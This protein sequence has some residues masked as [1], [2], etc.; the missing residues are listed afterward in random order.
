MSPE[1]AAISIF[2]NTSQTWK[3]SSRRVSK[4]GKM[5]KK[6]K[7]KKKEKRHESCLNSC[8]SGNHEGLKYTICLGLSISCVLR[9][10][11]FF[12]RKDRGLNLFSGTLHWHK[13]NRTKKTFVKTCFTFA[14][15][16][17]N[18][19]TQRGEKSQP[20][21]SEIIKKHLLFVSLSA[22]VRYVFA[23]I[24]KTYIS[25]F[26]VIQQWRARLSLSLL[27]TATVAVSKAFRPMI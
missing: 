17:Y 11:Y 22:D 20:E 13:E 6:K 9:L 2:A 10:H 21:S 1:T 3:L 23:V 15:G 16:S 27:S 7:E 25:V 4:D 14:L 26:A 8:L 19:S 5:K 18:L 12:V 24:V